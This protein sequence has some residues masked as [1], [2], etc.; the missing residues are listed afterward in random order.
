MGTSFAN[1]QVIGH[2]IDVVSQAL[3]ERKAK[4]FRWLNVFKNQYYLGEFG[5]GRISVLG[6]GFN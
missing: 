3:R 4:P 1:I 2:S 5:E 6:D